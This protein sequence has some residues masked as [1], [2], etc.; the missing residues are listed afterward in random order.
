MPTSGE[1]ETHI[2]NSVL[3]QTE[4][5]SSAGGGGHMSIIQASKDSNLP[6]GQA[7]LRMLLL[8]KPTHILHLATL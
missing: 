7:S 3:V 5:L 8:P 4:P 2:D 1:L 6:L